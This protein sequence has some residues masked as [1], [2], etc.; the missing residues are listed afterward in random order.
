GRRNLVHARTDAWAAHF[1]PSL[2][3]FPITGFLCPSY[4]EG[5]PAIRDKV[6]VR[7]QIRARIEHGGSLAGGN[8]EGLAL[9]L[10]RR[11]PYRD[12]AVGG[13]SDGPGLGISHRSR[14]GGRVDGGFRTD[15]S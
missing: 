7:S 6:A 8:A 1:A 3:P 13:L 5:L 10:C 4:G 12:Y 15:R 2:F 14:V 9:P 11:G